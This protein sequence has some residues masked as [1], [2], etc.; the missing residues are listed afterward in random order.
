MDQGFVLSNEG[1]GLFGHGEEN[2][3]QRQTSKLTGLSV[4]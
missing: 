4:S 3:S 1:I 2:V